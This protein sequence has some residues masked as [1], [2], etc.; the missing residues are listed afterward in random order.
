MVC[1]SKL[2]PCLS[3]VWTNGKT[4]AF[5]HEKLGSEEFKTCAFHFLVWKSYFGLAMLLGPHLP[6]LP[7]VLENIASY[8][9]ASRQSKVWTLKTREYWLILRYLKI[10][11][12]SEWGMLIHVPYFEPSQRFSVWQSFS[13]WV[14]RSR[15]CETWRLLRSFVDK[16]RYPEGI[17]VLLLVYLQSSFWES[18]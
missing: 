14:P 13:V 7:H 17:L 8:A 3:G 18:N 5:A 12:F 15:E 11:K 1:R 4:V 10:S 9:A 16:G 2:R 6:Y